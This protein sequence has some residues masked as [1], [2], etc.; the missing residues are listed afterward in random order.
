MERLI[1]YID[2]VRCI[3][4]FT[5]TSKGPAISH[6]PSVGTTVAPLNT[7]RKKDPS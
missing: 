6:G 2:D 5:F 4:T 1:H 3:E 7:F